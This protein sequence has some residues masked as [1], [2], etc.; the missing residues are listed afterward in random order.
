LNGRVTVYDTLDHQISGFSQQQS[1]GSSLSFTS[2]YGLIDV[3]NLPVVSSGSETATAATPSSSPPVAAATKER[4][5]QG[6]DVLA[7][8]EKLA[9]LRAK[10]VL[11]EEEFASKKAE[12]LGRL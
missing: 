2:Q 6:G 7:L 5:G 12:L 4:A 11:T 1:F 9:D 3:A 8:I 10:G